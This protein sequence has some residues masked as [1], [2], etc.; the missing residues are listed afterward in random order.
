[1]KLI[2]SNKRMNKEVYPSSVLFFFVFFANTNF[3]KTLVGTTLDE[4]SHDVLLL[5]ESKNDEDSGYFSMMTKELLRR[6][7]PRL[8]SSFCSSL[9][10][11]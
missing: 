3:N 6:Y 11:L 8:Y 9:T 4:D 7:I 2:N 1:M 5:V 10:R